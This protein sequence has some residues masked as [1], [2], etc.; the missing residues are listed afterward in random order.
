MNDC[1]QLSCWINQIWFSLPE[2]A[3]EAIKLVDTL[4]EIKLPFTFTLDIPEKTS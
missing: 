4:K 1:K 2:I 3:C